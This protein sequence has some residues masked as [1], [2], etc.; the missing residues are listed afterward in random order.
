MPLSPGYPSIHRAWWQ[1]QRHQHQHGWQNSEAAKHCTVSS[2]EVATIGRSSSSSRRGGSRP[3]LPPLPPCL[4]NL[5]PSRLPP[6]GQAVPAWQ[7]SFSAGGA[8]APTCRYSA[9]ADDSRRSRRSRSC[10]SPTWGKHG[11][12]S[13]HCGKHSKSACGEA[14]GVGPAS[15]STRS[16]NGRPVG[17]SPLPA[18]SLLFACLPAAASVPRAPSHHHPCCA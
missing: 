18:G 12:K 4:L 13:P 7:P 14:R 10:R 5:L 9:T 17:R 2:T 11:E 8:S 16:A 1:Q 3:L 6:G 15:C